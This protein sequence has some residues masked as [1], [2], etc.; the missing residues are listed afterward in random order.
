MVGGKIF[1]IV[2]V[3][4]IV[5]TLSSS[6][7]FGVNE[8]FVQDYPSKMQDIGI[9]GLL[10]YIGITQYTVPSPVYEGVETDVTV[11][12]NLY[13]WMVGPNP[14]DI[15]LEITIAE[16]DPTIGEYAG[17]DDEYIEDSF[18]IPSGQSQESGSYY[19]YPF[20]KTY[21]IDF[22]SEYGLGEPLPLEIILYIAAYYFPSGTEIVTYTNATYA[23]DVTE[24]NTNP[25]IPQPQTTPS[26]TS[27]TSTVNVNSYTV[28]DAESGI[29][30]YESRIDENAPWFDKGTVSNFDVTLSD[31]RHN[32]YIKAVDKAGNTA[33]GSIDI[34]VDTSP[35]ECSSGY[36]CESGHW[37]PTNTP[38]NQGNPTYECRDGNMLGSDVYVRYEAGVCTSYHAC[39][40]AYFTDWEVDDNCGGDEYCASD[41]DDSCTSCSTN[42]D[43]SCESSSCYGVDPDCTSSGG[44]TQCSGSCSNGDCISA[45]TYN[46]NDPCVDNSGCLRPGALPYWM[47][48]QAITTEYAC[49]NGHMADDD[50]YYKEWNRYCSGTSPSCNGP[51]AWGAWKMEDP[52][53][54][55]NERCA[56]DGDTS[57][58]TV[59]A[60]TCN[61]ADDDYD[62]EV[63]EGLTGSLCPKQQGVCTSS[64]KQCVN[65]AWQGCSASSYGSYYESTEVSCDNKDNDCDGSTDESLVISCGISNVGAC[66]Y[67]TQTCTSGAWDQCTGNTDPTTEACNG[68]DDDCDSSTDE[69]IIDPPLCPLQQGV[70]EGSEEVCSSGDWDD[71]TAA[72]YG[73]DYQVTET[74]CDDGND[75]DCDGFADLNDGDCTCT[76]GETNPCPNQNGVCQGSVETCTNQQW[77]GCNYSTIPDYEEA[78]VSCDNKDNNCDGSTDESLTQQCGTTDVGECTFSTETCQ[79]GVW[80]NCNAIMPTGEV[81]DNKD[82][83][84]D[85]SNDENLGQTTCG[86]GVCEHTIDNCVSGVPQTCD[87]FEGA[88]NEICDSLDN[89]CNGLVDDKEECIPLVVTIT[90][91]INNISYQP[92]SVDLNWTVNKDVTWC[93]YSFDGGSNL[94]I[95]NNNVRCW[96]STNLGQSEP[97]NGGDAI[98]VTTGG[99]HTCVLKSNGNVECWGKSDEGQINPYNAGDAI[100]VS[101][102]WYNTCVLKSNGNVEC[103][104]DNL[105]GQSNPYNDGDAIQI[106]SGGYHTCVLKLNGN[107]ECWGYN[108][109]GES[110]PYNGGDAIQIDTGLYHT[111]ALK[112]NGNVE[113][114]GDNYAGK[115][116]PYIGGDAIHVAA[117]G[118]HTCVLK[119][120]KNVEC[121]GRNED[122]RT[123]PYNAGD[124]IQI[125]TG[126][127][128]TCILKPS[129]NVECQ[130][131]NAYDQSNPYNGGDAIQVYTFWLHNCVVTSSPKNVSLTSL[132]EG[133]HNITIYCNDT[134]GNTAQSDYV[135]FDVIS[136][137][138]LEPYLINPLTDTNVSK[139]KFFDFSSGVKCVDGDVCGDV[140]VE[141]DP[142]EGEIIFYNDFESG[143]GNWS[144]VGGDDFD[145]TRNSGGTPSSTTGPTAAHDSAYYMYTESSTPNYPDKVAILEGPI[146]PL[147][148]YKEE[149]IEFWYHM[150]GSTMGVLYLEINDTGGSWIE[151]WSKSG[152]QGNQWYNAVVDLSS[153]SDSRKLRFRVVTSSGYRSDVALDDINITLSGNKGTIPMND[154][155]PFYTIDENPTVCYDMKSNDVCETNWVINA[156]GEINNSYEFFVIYD[157]INY[158]SFI[159][160]NETNKVTITIIEPEEGYLLYNILLTKG[161]NLISTPL[162]L[163][164]KNINSI[165]PDNNIT[166][167]GYRNNSWFTPTEIENKL[168]YWLKTNE[169][170]NLTLFGTEIENKT[171]ELAQGWNLIGYPYLEEK[172]ISD[173]FPNNPIYF[174]NATW[175]SYVPFRTSNTLN[176]FVPSYGYWVK[177]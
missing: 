137:G 88:I 36:C 28:T 136:F 55:E 29:D 38:C 35:P 69:D 49:K 102:G 126:G 149:K 171:I 138:N 52:D 172:N 130:G 125:A 30:H 31:G 84:C 72:S 59:P 163:P 151:L 53:C 87:P 73:P 37:L 129:G 96:G 86:L 106:A 159:I 134:S 47:C 131:W 67:G 168:G 9:L 70:C 173:I 61:G 112:E 20:S 124:A 54:N 104:G 14:P 142:T 146:L 3:L 174:Y 39:E 162:N 26:G 143:L 25:P 2:L 107:V 17:N 82:N 75:N 101:A 160:P 94:N 93:G 90:S 83:N 113:C 65:G 92:T 40:G 158:S 91:P 57:C 50:V 156:T 11:S 119:E 141:L 150:Y 58:T 71:C 56:S 169:S 76:N 34:S 109:S 166:I 8:S 46:P 15:S 51:Y 117:G 95:M 24:D 105:Y 148:S 22:S 115:S 80:I 77:P 120:N 21:S 64:R 19:K 154:G 121:W 152:D 175:S 164:D 48:Q 4:V 170:K 79:A 157:A 144:N 114:W 1:R 139:N 116:E 81:C 6:L 43:D 33:I 41:G 23:I 133:P 103:W 97:Y 18:D 68:V 44:N 177:N 63:D 123:N 5:F 27:T 176:Y 42:C 161:W 85:G 145:W 78:E 7:V 12:G 98:Q 74:S 32:I 122:G 66:Q 110:K 153:Y 45:C 100:Q 132:P 89:D 99:F 128:N 167:F 60:E 10:D 118:G 155:T 135:Y 165:F 108:N 13:V 127:H 62:G 16:D 147:D 140:R 111:C